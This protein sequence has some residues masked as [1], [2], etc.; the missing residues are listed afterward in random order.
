MLR[1]GGFVNVPQDAKD[2]DG[3]SLT[4][5]YS[6]RVERVVLLGGAEVNQ[7]TC[8]I[9]KKAI[10]RHCCSGTGDTQDS[11]RGSDDREPFFITHLFPR[12][13]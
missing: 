3:K 9:E 7:R 2:T 8:V 1:P 6:G 13:A 4:E 12:E 11:P 5:V 10:L